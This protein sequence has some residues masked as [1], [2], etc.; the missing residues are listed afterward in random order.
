MDP[1]FYFS[2]YLTKNLRAENFVT[3]DFFTGQISNSTGDNIIFE[4]F[5]EF[6]LSYEILELGPEWIFYSSKAL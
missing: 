4:Y 2:E 6:L 5:L 1:F 3:N